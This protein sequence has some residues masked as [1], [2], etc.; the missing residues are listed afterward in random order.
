VAVLAVELRGAVVADRV[1]D[2]CD[3]AAPGDQQ[4]SR[5]L[6]ADPFLEL[7]RLV[8]ATTRKCR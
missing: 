4:R 3:I 2:A 7:R 5:L 6:Q 1:A 8:M